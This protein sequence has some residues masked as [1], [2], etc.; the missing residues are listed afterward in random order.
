MFSTGVWV[1]GTCVDMCL[2][3]WHVLPVCVDVLCE[4]LYVRYAGQLMVCVCARMCVHVSGLR[5]PLHM[6]FVLQFEV[7]PTQGCGPLEGQPFGFLL[8]L[9]QGPHPF[10]MPGLPSGEKQEELPSDLPSFPPSPTR[11]TFSPQMIPTCPW[12]QAKRN[13]HF[14]N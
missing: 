1:T 7:P 13:P 6:G 4:C 2:C 8:P 10:P 9:L 12:L 5:A 14:T 11:R 3:T